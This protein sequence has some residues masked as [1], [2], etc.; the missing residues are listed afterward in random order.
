MVFMENWLRIAGKPVQVFM[1]YSPNNGLTT[2][3]A[4]H[5]GAAVFFDTAANYFVM[6]MTQSKVASIRR[7]FCRPSFVLLLATGLE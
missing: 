7:F 3:K 1:Q 4:A 5:G 6:M 2:K